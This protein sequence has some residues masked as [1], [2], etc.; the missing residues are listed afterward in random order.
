[1]GKKIYVGNL[2]FNTTEGALQSL[3]GTYGTVV[4]AKIITDRYSGESKG[5]GFVEMST[6]QEAAA[7]IGAANGMEIDGRQIKVNEAV[8]KPRRENKNYSY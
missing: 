7:A 2:A 1:M 5:F 3:F 6:D 4:S 8:D